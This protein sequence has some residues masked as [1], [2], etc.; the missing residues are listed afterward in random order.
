MP[1]GQDLSAWYPELWADDALQILRDMLVMGGL[2]RQVRLGGTNMTGDTVNVH[3]PG[4]IAAQDVTIGTAVTVQTASVTQVQIVLNKHK[5]APFAIY[6][7]EKAKSK[8]DLIEQNVRPAI[9]S[10]A[11]AIEDALMDEYAN[12]TGTSVGTYG[13]AI[14]DLSLPTLWRRFA[15]ANCPE[16]WS[17]VL[18]PK[19]YENLLIP[20]TNRENAFLAAGYPESGGLALR[21]AFMGT[22]AGMGFY[23]SNRINKNTAT[24]PDEYYGMA[25]CRETMALATAQLPESA[26]PGTRMVRVSDSEFSLRIEIARQAE[27]SR[28]LIKVEALYGTKTVRATTGFEVKS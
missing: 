10:I 22:K 3:L 27:Y 23:R 8:H 11:E 24:S 14:S 17:V 7:V 9:Q 5:A 2:V 16:P 21:R 28:D 1:T 13:T 19:D 4:A 6:D 20:T 25:F 12:F 18:H 15:E 26:S